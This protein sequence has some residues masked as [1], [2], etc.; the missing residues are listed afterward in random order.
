[1]KVITTYIA[2]TKYLNEDGTKRSEILETLILDS[3]LLIENYYFE[4]EKAVRILTREKR[5]VGNVPREY[6]EL[7]FDNNQKKYV[8]NILYKPIYFP[9]G[10]VRH[11][12]AIYIKYLF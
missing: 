9:N 3:P 7:V 5:C 8:S 4:G 2:G 6:A 12:I 1:M 11:N 10:S